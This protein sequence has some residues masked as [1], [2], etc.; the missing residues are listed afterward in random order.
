MVLLTMNTNTNNVNVLDN[1]YVR[2]VDT[3]GTD[4]SIVNAA[5]V[6]YDK[7]SEEF[8]SKDSK[9]IEFLIREGHTS[10]FR[11][12]ALTFEVYAPLFMP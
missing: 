12:A 3:L 4:L 11:H 9:L 8:S 2:L 5:R 6:S 1:G 10:P 7:E